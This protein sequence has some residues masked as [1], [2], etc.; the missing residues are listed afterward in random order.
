MCMVR[1]K[2]T[3]PSTPRTT[4]MAHTLTAPCSH[5]LL[6]LV[7]CLLL[8]AASG[9]ADVRIP[10]TPSKV[11]AQPWQ[12]AGA[13]LSFTIPQGDD[14]DDAGFGDRR[15]VVSLASGTAAAWH[16]LTVAQAPVYITADLG[17]ST[18]GGYS[19]DVTPANGL[20][21]TGAS[22]TSNVITTGAPQAV[23]QVKGVPQSTAISV[24]WPAAVDNGSPVTFYTVT[25][26]AE[27]GSVVNPVNVTGSP[28]ATS[29]IITGLVNFV[30]YTFTVTAT[31]AVG[32]SAPTTTS[33]VVRPQG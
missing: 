28:P 25:T 2:N 21:E 11:V 26:V 12:T 27:D 4:H 3:S 29:T 17:L 8:L 22:V 14:Y 24:A 18:G 33:D 15:F 13:I 10:A 9:V 32:T 19:F 30:G 31:N 5:I 1:T 16:D 6:L 20:G 23:A 7:L